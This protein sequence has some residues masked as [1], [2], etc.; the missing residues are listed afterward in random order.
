MRKNNLWSDE[1]KILLFGQNSK[2]YVRWTPG[3]AHHLANAIPKIHVYVDRYMCKDRVHKFSSHFVS[4]AD[5]AILPWNSTTYTANQFT[6]INYTTNKVYSN[7]KIHDK[8][9]H[10]NLQQAIT[11]KAKLNSYWVRSHVAGSGDGHGE[12]S[13]AENLGFLSWGCAQG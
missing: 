3:T 7:N 12:W 4:D 9:K 2:H 10:I 5:F 11:I 6:Q 1:T 13:G 8:N